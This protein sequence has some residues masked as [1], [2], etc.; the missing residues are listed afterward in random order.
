MQTNTE[1]L[2]SLLHDVQIGGKF[3]RK[4]AMA[5]LTILIDIAEKMETAQNRIMTTTDPNPSS[6]ERG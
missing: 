2:R 3:E 4:E 1:Q 6:P 5:L